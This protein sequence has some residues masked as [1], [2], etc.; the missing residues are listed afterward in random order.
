MFHNAMINKKQEGQLYQ[1]EIAIFLY[2][3][4]CEASYFLLN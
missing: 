2:R 4:S 3:G 1:N